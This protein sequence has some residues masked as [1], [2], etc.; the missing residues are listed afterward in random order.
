MDETQTANMIKIAATPAY[1]RKKK[2]MDGFRKLGINNNPSMKEFGIQVSERMEQ[3]DARVLEAPNLVY[4]ESRIARV[5]R[6]VWSATNTFYAPAGARNWAI[7][8][9][10]RYTRDEQIRSF[11]G[12]LKQESHKMG[13]NLGEYGGCTNSDPS[14]RSIENKLSE[15]RSCDLVIVIVPDRGPTYA[16]VKQKAELEFG[17]LTQCV[18]SFTVSR[19][20]NPA[21]VNNILLKINAKLNGI[22]HALHANSRP[23]CFARPIIIMGADVTHPSPDSKGVPSIAAVTASHDP[24]ALFK[25]NIECRL[26]PP[27]MEIIED[28]Q[29]IVK[30]QLKFFNAK[31]NGL[32]PD[33]IIFYRDGVGDG[34]FPEVLSK[35]MTAIRSACLS[36]NA[37]YKPAVTF[38]VVQ[39][40]HHTRFFPTRPEDEDGK[41]KNVPPGL[42]VD[43][44][45]TS[46]TDMDFYLVSHQS[47]QGTSRPTKYCV[48]H[49]DANMSEDD[50]EQLT[51][52][53]CH[54][55]SRCNRSVSYPAPTYYAHL[56]AFRAKAYIEGK[57]IDLDNLKRMQERLCTINETFSRNS[58]MFFV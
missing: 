32:K 49:D 17:I 26:Q 35:E 22:N 15:L 57:T 3:V 16:T 5:N 40:R 8:N 50:V 33:R 54:L 21:T 58:P 38:L 20:M 43:T 24:Q 1:E 48:L 39:K 53:L 7:L 12:L 47:I 46:P 42:V 34:Q 13:M 31:T 52:Y 41:N 29:N 45:I 44:K 36:L 30:N 9:L 14:P 27:R 11:V 55:F 6:G 23:A 2:I 28:L 4:N 10:E 18:K 51:Y 37:N 19:K 56:A 25:Y